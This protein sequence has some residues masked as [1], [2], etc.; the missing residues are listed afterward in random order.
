MSKGKVL[1]AMSGGVD[2]SVAA[3]L[4]K[5]E[6]YDVT[7]V[8]LKLFDNECIG[9]ARTKTCCSLEDVEDARSVA[10]KLGIPHYVFN[11]KDLFEQ[12][13]IGKFIDSYE[14][15]LT[16]NP[17]IDCNRYIKFEELLRRALA[18]EMDYI[19][20]GHYAV[21]EYSEER[22]RYLLKRASDRHKD[23]T[24]ALYSL[25][26]EQLARTLLP[27]GNYSKDV[28]RDT[29]E[30][31]G[32]RNSRKPDSQD[33]CFVQ[34]GNYT[35]FIRMKTGRE[36]PGGDFIDQNGTV[37]GRHKGSIRY[38]IGQRRGLGDSMG[39]RMYVVDKDPLRNTVT[40]GDESS[41]YD[42]GLIAGDL[43]LSMENSIKGERQVTAVTRYNGPESPAVI[44][45]LEERKI[46][47]RF[48]TPHR[49]VTPGQAVVFYDGDTVY[50][51]GTIL[52]AVKE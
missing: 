49:A 39:K 12:K 14:K 16:P 18:M 31:F 42:R 41:L 45:P 35:D 46:L 20:T 1:V 2:S 38:T 32:L 21:R 34:D 26:G 4:L 33:I 22:G 47:V 17:C 8:T 43:L 23:Q 10:N 19:A 5:E 29:A 27:L 44:S 51:G 37:I 25:S 3:A 52:K 30:R 13:V 40:L 6:G 48:L 50:G 24:Y 11:F 7:G 15:G 9:V 36:F 28:V